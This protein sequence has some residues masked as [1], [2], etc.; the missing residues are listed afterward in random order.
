[1]NPDEDYSS[2]QGKEDL[3]QND[4]PIESKQPN[5]HSLS[6]TSSQEQLPGEDETDGQV[7]PQ[8]P[9]ISI[10]SSKPKILLLGSRRSGKTS[11]Q[12]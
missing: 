2:L 7:I 3:N 8:Q 5:I 11:I 6:V 1:M 4:Q 9:R 10:K 12:R